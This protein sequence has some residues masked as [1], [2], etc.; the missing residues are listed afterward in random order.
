MIT[1]SENSETSIKVDMTS[2]FLGLVVVPGQ[3]ITK[4]EVEELQNKEQGSE[5]G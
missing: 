3:H 2:R 1:A 4:I 5:D